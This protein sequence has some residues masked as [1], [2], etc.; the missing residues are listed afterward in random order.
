MTNRP[1]LLPQNPNF[2]AE[3]T[4]HHNHLTSFPTSFELIQILIRSESRK[5]KIQIR[6]TS[7]RLL[8]HRSSNR[9][10]LYVRIG[11]QRRRIEISLRRKHLITRSSNTEKKKL[12]TDK[13]KSKNR[14]HRLKKKSEIRCDLITFEKMMRKKKKTRKG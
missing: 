2:N 11:E 1:H 13:I 5:E 12:K 4:F 6:L 7:A 3:I 9:K 10:G 8:R 14:D